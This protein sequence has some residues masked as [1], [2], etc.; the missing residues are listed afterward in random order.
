ME[1]QKKEMKGEW[2]R[3]QVEE[4]VEEGSSIMERVTIKVV[5]RGF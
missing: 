1:E 5:Q 3:K 2:K 4:E